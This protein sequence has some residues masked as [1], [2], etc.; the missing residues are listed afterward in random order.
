[1]Q[2]FGFNAELAGG[3][4]QEMAGQAWNIFRRSRSGGKCTRMT[5]RRWNK[6]SRNFPPARAV[7]LVGS[8][9]DPHIDLDRRVTAHAIKL[10]I[11]QHAQQTS[12]DI[13]RH[14]ANFIRNSVPPSACSKRPDGRY[15][16]R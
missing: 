3:Y 12:L 4:L 8:G 15:W 10:T 9:D 5:F 1:M 7:V 16:R 11:R 2:L 6:S 14:I 13:K